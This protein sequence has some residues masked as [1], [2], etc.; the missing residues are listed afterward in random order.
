MPFTCYNKETCVRQLDEEKKKNKE[1]HRDK[2]GTFSKQSEREREI[3]KT[4]NNSLF[5]NILN[6]FF[7]FLSSLLFLRSFFKC[8]EC[9]CKYSVVWCAIM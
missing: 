1:N 3:K 9:I 2:E 6:V 8:F 4:Y 5:H 7:L